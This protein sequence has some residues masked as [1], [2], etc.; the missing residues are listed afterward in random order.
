MNQS[1][2]SLQNPAIGDTINNGINDFIF[3]NKRGNYV[4]PARAQRAFPLLPA[5]AHALQQSS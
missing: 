3:V 1:S 4:L 5:R 2:A